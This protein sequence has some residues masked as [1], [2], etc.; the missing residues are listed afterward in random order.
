MRTLKI[1][2]PHDYLVHIGSGLEIPQAPGPRAILYDEAVEEYANVLADKLFISS[3]LGIDGGEGIKTITSYADVMSW[4]AKRALPRDTTLYV[5]GGGTLTDLGGFLAAT[6][7][8]GIKYVSIPTTTLAIVDASVGNKT[9]INLPEGKNLVGAFHAP[10]GVF[11]E[12]DN[13]HNLPEP[14]FKEGLVEAYKHG[15]IAGDELLLNLEGIT[16]DWTGLDNYLARAVSVKIRIVE[17]DPREKGERRKLNLGHTLAHALEAASQHTLSHGA[18]VA[19]GLLYSTLLGK[20]LG[21][22]DL[23]HLAQKLLDWLNPSGPP[24]LE[25]SELAPYLSRDKKKIGTAL[26]WVVPMDMGWLE[27]QPVSEDVLWNCYDEF[28]FLTK[29]PTYWPNRQNIQRT[30]AE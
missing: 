21:G 18:A 16:P 1:K 24:K 28:L 13:L 7:L 30:G 6:Y 15:I 14:I 5:V 20:S 2:Q 4:L 10:E 27:V 19:Y 26:N 8:R 25:W 11:A 22:T 17:N 3:R 12:L 23:V 9:G 29:N